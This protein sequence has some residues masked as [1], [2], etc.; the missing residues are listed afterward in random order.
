M[1]QKRRIQ[2]IDAPSRQ[3]Y[4]AIFNAKFLEDIPDAVSR[5]QSHRI[6]LVAS[7]G[8][9]ANSDRIS[10][11][12]S[13]LGSKLVHTKL[14]VGTHTPY[15][16]VRDIAINIQK[17]NIDCVISVGSCS[18]SDACKI[19]SLLANNLPSGFSVD[20]MESLVDKDRGIADSRNGSPLQPRQ[21]KLLVVPTSLSA[22][23][24]NA[25]SSATNSQGKKQHFGLWDQGQ[26]DLILLD[27]ELAST[28]PEDLWLSSGVRCIDHCV[29]LMCNPLS[30]EKGYE[31][32]NV[33]AEE[34]LKCMVAGLTEYKQAK[35]KGESGSQDE[36]HDLLLKGISECQF[37]SREALTGLLIWRVPM[38]PSHAIGHQVRNRHQIGDEFADHFT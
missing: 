22:S 1:L 27:P 21:C 11:L 16:D 36:D 15:A 26:P 8:L 37:G 12:Q 31:G 20:D 25:V 7:K 2:Q 14:G 38:G 5:W 13:T 10:R 30:S 17:H 19:A 29:E 9:A 3:G 32:V 28:S 35:G 33:H 4:D 24:W 34:G 23:E 18:Y 6:M